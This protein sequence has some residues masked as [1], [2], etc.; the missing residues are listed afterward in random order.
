MIRVDYMKVYQVGG[1]L[2]GIS[3]ELLKR[4]HMLS[5][6]FEQFAI[7]NSEYV[8]ILLR[9]EQKKWNG[10]CK[11]L[12]FGFSECT[13]PTTLYQLDTGGYECWFQRPDGQ[14]GVGFF[15]SEDWSEIILICDETNDNGYMLYNRIGA[16]FSICLLNRNACVF[17]GVVMEYEE[18][19]ILVMAAAGIGKST[20]TN[21][22]EKY[23]NAD[24]LNGDRCLCRR[25]E[26]RWYAYGMPWAGSSDKVL[27]RRVPVNLIVMLERG[28]KN[29]VEKLSAFDSE[30][31]LLQRIFGPVSNGR[32]QDNA[33]RYV[34]DISEKIPVVRLYCR[35]DYDSVKVLKKA[36]L[37]ICGS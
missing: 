36:I 27:N 20:H 8:D 15:I 14:T 17:H 19:G 31:S 1:F 33:Y 10:S 25:I 29:I 4:N 9:K 3:D 34:Q 28:K 2:I 32:L 13:Y 21:L 26:D 6:G 30:I 37:D 16:L 23:E 12:L 35:P 22:W 11:K 18:K 7:E 24:I 5:V